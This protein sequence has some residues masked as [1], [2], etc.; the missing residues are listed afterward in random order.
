MVFNSIAFILFLPI[1]FLLYWF[2]V[3]RNLKLQNAFVVAA[4]YLFYGWWDWRFLLLIALTTF[5]SYYSGLAIEKFTQKRK[6]ILWSN[7]LL[8]LGILGLFKY[9]NFFVENLEALLGI[10][11]DAIT[12][13][14]I[15]PVGISFYT[16]QALSY[17]I[18]VYRGKIE[19]TRDVA[20]FFA[21]IAFFPQLVAGPIERAT[22]LLPQFLAKRRFEY[23]KGVD[24]SRLILLGFFK[25]MVIADNCAVYVNDVFASPDSFGGINLWIAAVLF[26][27]QIYGDFSG[28]SD[29]AIGVARLFGINLMRN[30]RNPYL[31]RDIAEFWRRWHISL[32]TWFRDYVYIPLG[33]SRCSKLKV[34][35]NTGIIFLLSGFW[36]GAEWT[37]IAWGAYN[38][39]LF[40][41]QI[42]RGTNRRYLNEPVMRESLLMGRTF[43]L[44]M[45]GWIL[46]RAENIHAAWHYIRR[47]FTNFSYVNAS[48]LLVGQTFFWIALLLA[49]EWVERH[50]EHAFDFSEHGLLSHAPVRWALYASVV[51]ICL[52]F[53]GQQG[54]FIYFRF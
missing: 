5:C 34:I 15:L 23:A 48:A 7:V 36:H 42:L 37:F 24:G 3:G 47:M 25:K 18:D 8:N 43:L 33:G 53:H 44:V 54:E 30:F 22:N 31:A 1:T 6:I 4:S 29:I 20:A 14:L 52:A 38:A 26:A 11:L 46:F 21:F 2:V 45:I 35:R 13:N 50:K 41:P 10:N 19:A 40:I 12:L 27:F 9:Y 51:I 32:T 28:Y 39:V 17:T 16:F 49:L